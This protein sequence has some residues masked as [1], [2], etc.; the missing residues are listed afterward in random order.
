MIKSGS[1]SIEFE[2][3]GNDEIVDI[4]HQVAQAVSKFGL[5]EGIVTVFVVGSTAAVTTMEFEPGLEADVK[6][7][8]R[9]VAPAGDWRHD[10]TW[11]EANGHS[12]LRA[13]M[14]GPSLTIPVTNSRMTLGTWQQIV[15][16]DSDVKPRHRTIIVQMAGETKG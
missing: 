2:T 16:I 10:A 1:E 4:T 15:I 6:Q 7:W 12:H 13:S 14:I 5:A 3:R 9:D 11:S 8:L